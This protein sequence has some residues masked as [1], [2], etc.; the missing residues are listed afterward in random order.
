M[1]DQ[2]LIE[3]VTKIANTRMKINYPLVSESHFKESDV[4]YILEAA[5]E[6][7]KAWKE[8]KKKC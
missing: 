6:L 5:V 1:I 3:G 7:I 8:M 2:S 4:Q